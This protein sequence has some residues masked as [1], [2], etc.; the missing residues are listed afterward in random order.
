MSE[1][2]VVTRLVGK[3]SP[4][5]DES[6]SGDNGVAAADLSHS[7]TVADPVIQQKDRLI[8]SKVIHEIGD[9]IEGSV[10]C[11]AEGLYDRHYT[12]AVCERLVGIFD[13]SDKGREPDSRITNVECFIEAIH[14]SEYGR[15][16]SGGSSSIHTALSTVAND[17]VI[18]TL[19]GWHTLPGWL[20]EGNLPLVSRGCFSIRWIIEVSGEFMTLTVETFYPATIGLEIPDRY[21]AISRCPKLVVGISI[22]KG[23]DTTHRII[24]EN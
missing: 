14:R 8:G 5:V 20:G 7:I 18:R 11:I 15:F 6:R 1:A 12:V 9:G 23:G 2:E 19:P 3:G 17:H 22:V 13:R 24:M 10:V 21:Q 4:T 16:D